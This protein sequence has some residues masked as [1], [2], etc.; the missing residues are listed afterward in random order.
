MTK[1]ALF[2]KYPVQPGMTG[3]FKLNVTTNLY[4][5]DIFIPVHII[6]GVKDNP[7]LLLTATIHGNEH[8]PIRTMFQLSKLIDPQKLKGTL[9][10]V[11]VANPV[12]FARDKRK[13]PEIDI[14][15]ANM[16]RVFP[17]RRSRP[18][19]GEGASQS[20][21]ITL[22][23]RLTQTIA[24]K[25]I[26]FANY[27]IDFHCHAEGCCLAELI[28]PLPNDDVNGIGRQMAVHFGWPIIHEDSPLPG[29]SGAYARSLG[30]PR[31]APEI[32]GS[33]LGS[34]LESIFVD[35]QVKGTLNVMRSL[36]MYPGD[37]EVYNNHKFIYRQ[38]PKVRPTVSGYLVS[39]KCPENLYGP[40][41]MA[42]EVMG[43]RVAKGDFLGEIF[44]PYS[45][46]CVE[47]LLS[48]A[49]GLLYL[50]RRD[51]VI[52]AGALA[53]GI[54]AYNGARFE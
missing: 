52:Q 29:T 48:P 12:A 36:G 28:C 14:D 11:P 13:T 3:F 43:V 46:E 31:F 10:M 8:P 34:H 53:F 22:T 38:C 25:I 49:D 39:R 54:A 24:D 45:L 40:E 18:A 27:F 21:D 35:I 44:D 33:G 17:G 1:E 16:N 26:P 15:F 30:I 42:G 50:S 6:R 9:I 5:Q 2:D 20:T 7:C 37:I 41:I 19:F 32:G 51:G 47:R 23:E 4:G